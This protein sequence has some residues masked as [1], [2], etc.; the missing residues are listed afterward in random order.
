M[1]MRDRSTIRPLHKSYRLWVS[2]GI[3]LVL[4]STAVVCAFG[5]SKLAKMANEMQEELQAAIPLATQVQQE[6]LDGNTSKAVEITKRLREHTGAA[7][8]QTTSDLWRAAENVPF[9]GDDLR[10]ARVVSETADDLARDALAPAAKLSLSALQPVDGQIDVDAL[11]DL[12]PV[13]DSIASAVNEAQEDLA[14]IPR[15]ALRDEVSAAIDKLDSATDRA[16]AVLS[17]LRVPVA[18][19][20]SALG[21]EQPRNYL[22][23]FQG[24]S[25]VRAEGGNPAAMVLV[26]VDNGKVS[27]TGQAS[28]TDFNN[29][30]VRD[31]VMELDPA[32]E[33]IYSDIVG[34]YIPNITSTPDFPTTAALMQAYWH[35]EFATPLDGIISFDPVG[36]S[37]LLEA[38]GPVEMP[39]GDKLTAERAVPL[40]LNEVYFRYP[41]GDQSDAFFSTAASS[42]FEA[43]TGGAGE[44]SAMV[45][46]LVKSATEGRLMMWSPHE[47]VANAIENTVLQGTLPAD[48]SK[49]TTLGVYFND[50]TGSKMD[51]YVDAKVVAKTNQCDVSSGDAPQF[52]TDV[53]LT[54]SITRDEASTLPAYITGVHYRPGDIATDFVVYGPVGATI[55]SWT[56]NGKE[57]AA[58]ATGE[59][60]G[61]PVVRLN[62]VL[63][64][65]QSVT[66]SYT[67]TGAP[68]QEYGEFGVDTTPMVRDTPVTI[69]GCKPEE[70]E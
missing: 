62:Y 13:I 49:K 19:L 26:N 56:V 24:N 50:T 15:E 4:V 43:L 41:E 1:R 33:H 11:Q 48:N 20:P 21:A 28:S 35:E 65:G 6:I 55:D 14:A 51:Y 40:L 10:A 17:E 60:D 59:I 68:D 57:Y 32:V 64:P 69:T 63:K 3:V 29:S 18:V 54:N 37:Y 8:A 67:M 2:V 70:D 38:T 12:I 52:Q 30:W 61:R 7:R 5:V 9:F 44:P 39:T 34:K 27:I 46:A 36:L 53:T 58:K 45:S 16:D 31:P 25:E 42:I 47:D 66:V 23:I 22:L